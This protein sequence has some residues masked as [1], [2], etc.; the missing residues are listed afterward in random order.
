MIRMMTSKDSGRV[1]ICQC[2]PTAIEVHARMQV[3]SFLWCGMSTQQE[4]QCRQSTDNCLMSMLAY[5]HLCNLLSGNRV[6]Q[7]GGDRDVQAGYSSGVGS[8]LISCRALKQA[9]NACLA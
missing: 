9:Q 1:Y 5:A 3:S 8:A 7:I 6:A 2:N 4:A